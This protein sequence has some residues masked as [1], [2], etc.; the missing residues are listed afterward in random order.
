MYIACFT[1]WRE[2]DPPRC[3][4]PFQK[5]TAPVAGGRR[6][7]AIRDGGGVVEGFPKKSRFETAISRSIG[8]RSRFHPATGGAERPKAPSGPTPRPPL[9]WKFVEITPMLLFFLCPFPPPLPGQ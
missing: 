4:G 8:D 2:M 7:T 6:W 5:A 3:G 9:A 1:E